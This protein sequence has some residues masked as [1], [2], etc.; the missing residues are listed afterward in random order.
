MLPLPP[1]G[2]PAGWSME[3]WGEY[4]HEYYQAHPQ[5]MPA[6]LTQ[7]QQDPL[8]S[9]PKIR[10]SRDKLRSRY[11]SEKDRIGLA[12]KFKERLNLSLVVLACLP[13]LIFAGSVIVEEL[14]PITGCTDSAADNFDEQAEEDDGSC[15]YSIPTNNGVISEDVIGDAMG[16]IG[17]Y[18][19]IT[20]YYLS[21]FTFFLCVRFVMPPMSSRKASRRSK[22]AWNLGDYALALSILRAHAEHIGTPKFSEEYQRMRD[23]V[24]IY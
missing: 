20:L 4:G 1:E 8:P 21:I 7:S 12:V 2:L 9:S 6:A 17:L 15:R 13:M 22:V 19:L 18:A 24:D 23:E 14:S 11:E 10:I 5:E 3:Q 16:I